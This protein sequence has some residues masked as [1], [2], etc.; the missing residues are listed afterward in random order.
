MKIPLNKPLYQVIRLKIGDEISDTSFLFDNPETV[1]RSIAMTYN[2]V[3][4]TVIE[5]TSPDTL[6]SVFV[7]DRLELFVKKL[8]SLNIEDMPVHF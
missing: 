3:P 7:N 5:G 8:H 4:H 2:K 1:R 6:F